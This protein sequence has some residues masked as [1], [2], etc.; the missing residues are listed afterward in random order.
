[1]E[2]NCPPATSLTD[3][4]SQDCP[5]NL[6]QIQRF[7][8]QR[9]GNS[10]DND[11]ATTP[12]DITALADWQVLRTATDST[13]IVVTPLISADPSITAGDAITTGGGDNS[14]LNGVEEVEGTNPASATATFKGLAPAIE[15]ALK[16]LVCEAD[17][18]VYFFLQGGR[19]AAKK[20]DETEFTGFKAQSLFVSDRNNQ[21]F[22]TKDTNLLTFQLAAGWSEDLEIFDAS[23]LDFNPL[24]QL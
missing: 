9:G 19:I 16:A 12:L 20:I 7:G 5:I 6:K 17:L 23:D 2:C 11:E 3:I 10:F 14:T 4:P 15:K 8:F 21:G 18:I 24:T 13:K 1:M 22:A